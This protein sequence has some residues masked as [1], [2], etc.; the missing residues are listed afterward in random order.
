MTM[1]RN[2]IA[3]ALV[4]GSFTE[5][6]IVHR[7]R[8]SL[9]ASVAET[10]S[11]PSRW[12]HMLGIA[13]GFFSPCDYQLPRK[14]FR[15]T[16]RR[17]A[18]QG[19]PISVAQVCRTGQRPEAAPRNARSSVLQSDCFMFF[20]EQLWNI[21]AKQLQ[22]CDKLLFVD[23]DIA[24]TPR[25]YLTQISDSLDH[26]DIVQPFGEAQWLDM[27]GQVFMRLPC[28]AREIQ[29][30][31]CPV[32]SEHHP[33]FAWAMT[34]NA[35]ERIGGWYDLFTSGAGDAAFAFAICQ[36]ADPEIGT[37][38]KAGMLM[39]AQPSY[40]AYRE[41][42]LRLN[43]RVGHVPGVTTIH[44]WHG[45]REN[46]GYLTRERYFPPP[47]PDDSHVYRR[48]DGLLE[49]AI[50]APLARDYFVMRQEDG[51]LTITGEANVCPL[52]DVSVS[53]GHGGGMVSSQ[54]DPFSRRSRI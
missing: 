17:L 35:F 53:P 25:N 6:A 18:R 45:E 20:K 41:R 44:Q 8:A 28:A 34:R 1:M 19:V 47:H 22:D 5:T 52:P 23:S 39:A 54:P 49:W 14:H 27:N 37:R 40:V 29:H 9:S 46:R 38:A 4:D 51:A 50:S 16:M 33:G 48:P 11:P 7:A 10:T 13:L 42:V 30:G 21:A 24:F 36:Q 3:H 26:F 31:R 12:C 43:L 2:A 15:N 32:L